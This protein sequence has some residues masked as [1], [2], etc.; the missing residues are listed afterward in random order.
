MCT[1]ETERGKNAS[2]RP[3]TR[4]NC[5]RR[6]F[7]R[8]KGLFRIRTTVRAT[9]TGRLTKRVTNTRTP[10]RNCENTCIH[11]AA[12][13]QHACNPDVATTRVYI[14]CFAKTPALRLS[15][16]VRRIRTRAH[17]YLGNVR[18][19]NSDVNVPFARVRYGQCTA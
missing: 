19:K 5:G 15:L 11:Y 16:R 1:R 3:R 9:I 17:T 12:V 14:K 6:T 13:T 7:C 8:A 10:V 2:Y 4:I 18:L